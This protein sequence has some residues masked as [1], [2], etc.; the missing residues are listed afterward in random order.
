M[1][2][3][4]EL[5][6]ASKGLP[7]ALVRHLVDDAHWPLPL[8]PL[9]PAHSVNAAAAQSAPHQA[10]KQ[11]HLTGVA[12]VFFVSRYPLLHDV[13]LDYADNAALLMHRDVRRK[14]RGP[15]RDT[16]SPERRRQRSTNWTFLTVS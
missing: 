3:A 16:A 6:I 15:H 8:A 13:A 14:D 7:V 9:P 11:L 5:L 2:L 1:R 12:V 10:R 4:T